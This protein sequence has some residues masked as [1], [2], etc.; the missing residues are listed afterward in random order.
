MDVKD[1]VSYETAKKLKASGFLQEWDSGGHKY[2]YLAN[3]RICRISNVGCYNFVDEPKDNFDIPHKNY[4]CVTLWQAQKW[5]REVKAID[6]T[7][8]VYR[9]IDETVSPRKIKRS[10][11]C[12]ITTEDDEDYIP[13]SEDEKNFPS[14]EAALS[15]GIDEALDLITN[16][17]E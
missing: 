13:Y 16:K 17:T 3:D 9:E 10:Y 5:L 11:E 6:I 14:Y 15:A 8:S 2:L 12:E 1:F 4:P 7:I